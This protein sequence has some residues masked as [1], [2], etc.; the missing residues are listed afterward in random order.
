MPSSAVWLGS[1]KR[2]SGSARQ[3]RK[4]AQEWHGGISE[5]LAIICGMNIRRVDLSR[6]WAM[7]EEHLPTLKAACVDALD[8]LRGS[9]RD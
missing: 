4:R 1:A 8:R 6:I 3:L 5:D 9:G 2:L 7:V